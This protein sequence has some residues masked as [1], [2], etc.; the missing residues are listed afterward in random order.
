MCNIKDKNTSEKTDKYNYKFLFVL[1][2]TEYIKL[3][4]N[5]LGENICRV[6]MRG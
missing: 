1:K 5:K 6:N 4:D 2:K 3:K